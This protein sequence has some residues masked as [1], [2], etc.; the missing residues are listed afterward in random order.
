M[1]VGIDLVE[2]ERIRKSSQKGRFMERVFSEKESAL[3]LTKK[4]PFESMAGNWAAK[5][6]F[7]KAVK[8]GVRDFSLNEISVLR[9]ELGAPY[10]E[11]SGKAKELAESMGLD[12]DVSISHTKDYATAV[13]IAFKKGNS[14]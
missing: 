3:F 10:I 9:D 11:L 13:V 4:N 7:S 6:A 1:N 14:L 2:I 8:T 12:F 5:E